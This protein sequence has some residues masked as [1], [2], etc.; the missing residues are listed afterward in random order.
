MLESRDGDT[1]RNLV[2]VPSQISSSLYLSVHLSLLALSLT[3]LFFFLSKNT[4]T[5]DL[6]KLHIID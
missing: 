4:L 5:L 1:G 6:S 2:N 3:P